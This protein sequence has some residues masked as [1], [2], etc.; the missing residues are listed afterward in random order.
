MPAWHGHLGQPQPCWSSH[1]GAL[2]SDSDTE[3]EPQGQRSPGS[4]L[5]PAELPWASRAPCGIP[6]APR[7]FLAPRHLPKQPC[8]QGLARSWARA[9][10][11]L[12][13]SLCPQHRDHNL[14]WGQ[15][16]GEHR[17]RR[18][19]VAPTRPLVPGVSGVLPAAAGS[20]LV[21]REEPFPAADTETPRHF[22]ARASSRAEPGRG[23]GWSCPLGPPGALDK[24]QGQGRVLCGDTAGSCRASAPGEALGTET[25]LTQQEPP[26]L[27][28]DWV[29][30]QGRGK[31]TAVPG[32]ELSA[33]G[34]DG[35]GGCSSC[36]PRMPPCP[37]VQVSVCPAVRCQAAA[38]AGSSGGVQ[39]G[40]R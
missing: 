24:L 10:V 40:S 14:Q 5:G 27:I 7:D 28:V 17:S 12:G 36:S 3:A 18:S 16:L 34:G 13:A 4:R 30:W 29:Y 26:V 39:V 37:S 25:R 32:A 35:G 31:G 23:W 1:A 21:L 19:G 33:A 11:S 22:T 20:L 38:Q 6:T 9:R 15:E 2:H 8:W